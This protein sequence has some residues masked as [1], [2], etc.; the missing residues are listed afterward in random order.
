MI[1]VQT[2]PTSGNPRIN[3][4]AKAR[5]LFFILIERDDQIFQQSVN[6]MKIAQY[7]YLLTLCFQLVVQFYRECGFPR[8][9]HPF[10]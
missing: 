6:P 7:G 10:R 9:R 5:L 1:H 2:I 4:R 8:L 3:F